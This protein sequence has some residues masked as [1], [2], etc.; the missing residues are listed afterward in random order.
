MY[1]VEK[2][3]VV[4]R[5]LS[6]VLCLIILTGCGTEE[7]LAQTEISPIELWVVTEKTVWDGM[8]HQAKT[9]IK[10]FESENEDVSVK[11]DILPTNQE[12]RSVYLEKLRTEIIADRGPDV[13]LLPTSD[14][15]K[16]EYPVKYTTVKI[17][18]IFGD[19]VSSM[20]NGLFYDISE[21]YDADTE[22]KKEE[23]ITEVMNAGMFGEARYVLPLRFD[24]PVLCV[25]T[26]ALNESELDPAILEADYNTLMNTVLALGD[27]T[28][29]AG[30]EYSSTYGFLTNVIDYEN[31]E[32]LLNAEELTQHLKNEVSI[33]LET[34]LPLTNVSIADYIQLNTIPERKNYP[35][36][37]V[38][39]YYAMCYAAIEKSLDREITMLPLRNSDGLITATV[40]YYAAV[41]ASCDNPD[42][43][44]EFARLFLLQKSQWEVNRP[45][46]DSFHN[47][48]QTDGFV[49]SGWPVR[50]EGSVFPLWKNH[51][52]QNRGVSAEKAG[53]SERKSKVTG[54]G[55]ENKDMPVLNVHIDQVTFPL[56]AYDRNLSA[57]RMDIKKNWGSYTD[58]DILSI[59][60]DLIWDLQW[61]LAEG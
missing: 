10:Q 46:D 53:Q 37:V 41:G 58:A 35:M 8:N 30:V 29:T 14:Y 34:G 40:T 17:E 31:G 43:A 3:T 26:E 57:A 59:A 1:T 24:M 12:E 18:Q 60:E 42:L 28:W 16:L 13:Y 4:V 32:V 39:L 51:R 23:L 55:L 19:V 61:H 56:C 7:V 25:D 9:L 47:S 54:V 48:Y 36:Q 15:L 6:L 38:N 45:G 50:V 49:C 52:M 2:S 27:S 44:Y 11:L 5:F 20:R 21:Y 33:K 22:L